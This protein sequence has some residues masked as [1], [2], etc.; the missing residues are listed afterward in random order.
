MRLKKYDNNPILSPNSANAWENLVVCNP[1]V[2][3]EDGIFYMLYRAAGDDEEHIIRLGLATSKDGYDFRRASSQPVFGPSIDGPDAGGVEDPRIVKFDDEYYVTYAFRP[4]PPGQ[5]WKFPHD[6]VLRPQCGSHAPVFIKENLGNSGLA[7]TKDFRHFRR[8]GRITESAL[9]AY[10][11]SFHEDTSD[12]QVVIQFGSND[13]YQLNEENTDDYVERYVK[14]VLAVPSRKT[15]LFCIFPRN[16]Y[17]DY[18]T[19]VNKFIRILN[20]K[21]VAKLTGTGV[22]YLDVFDQLLMNGRLN[23]E[24]T[25]DDLHLNGKGYRILSTALKQAFNGQEHL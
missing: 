10:V 4:Y 6:V 12:C 20:E 22:I 25:I 24:L 9:L 2:W 11:E 18:S 8:L 15:Y 21:I 13:I 23:P 19:A 7:V 17:D 16:D 5:Y 14:A 1:G 3:Y